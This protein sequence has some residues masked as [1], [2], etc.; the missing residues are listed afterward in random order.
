MDAM[1]KNGDELIEWFLAL[2]SD[3]R[4]ESKWHKGVCVSAKIR[5]EILTCGRQGKLI[6]RGNVRAIQFENLGGGVYRAYLI[7]T[8]AEANQ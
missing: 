8:E 2:A 3:P 5:R 1:L 7:I 4:A 6:V